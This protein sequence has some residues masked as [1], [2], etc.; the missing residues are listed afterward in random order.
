MYYSEVG[1]YCGAMLI[2]P[3]S[4]APRW[5][6]MEGHRMTKSIMHVVACIIFCTTSL[7][8]RSHR[9]RS[10]SDTESPWRGLRIS[11]SGH[12][13]S[14]QILST[15]QQPRGFSFSLP[16]SPA[17]LYAAQARNIFLNPA[18]RRRDAA[19]RASM[20]RRMPFVFALDAFWR[21]PTL[22]T[23]RIVFSRCP[24]PRLE[25]D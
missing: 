21:R 20:L 11:I 25:K 14:H 12:F 4:G 19:A 1:V 24:K 18:V 22:P 10:S 13:I 17:C 2:T 16:E 9:V 6:D 3:T 15:L 23:R 7:L 8:R 5:D